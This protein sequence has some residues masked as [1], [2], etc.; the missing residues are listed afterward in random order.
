MRRRRPLPSLQ[1]D[2]IGPFN[3]KTATPGQHG[4]MNSDAE[5][6][7]SNLNVLGAVSQNDK[8]MTNDDHFDIY[9]P[10]TL[11]A[12]LRTW[13]G[14]RRCQNVQRVRT[15]IRAGISFARTFLEDATRLKKEGS[16][17]LRI[18]TI[19]LQH[20]RMRDALRVSCCGLKNMLQTYRDDAAHRSQL[21]GLIQEVEDFLSVIEPYSRG[22]TETISSSV[23]P[24]PTRSRSPSLPP[25]PRS[26]PPAVPS[27]PEAPSSPRRGAVA[28]LGDS[29]D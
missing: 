7:L 6:T 20:V 25:S 14:E 17:R 21:N 16:E 8:L 12:I 23:L 22:V 3:N 26:S 11:R 10:T 5:R 13:Y 19:I 27:P 9:T 28:G 2:V 24:S 1:S 18:D 29:S 4:C 15:T